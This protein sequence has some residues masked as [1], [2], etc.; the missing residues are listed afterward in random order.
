[1]YFKLNTNTY[2]HFGKIANIHDKKG[3]SYLTYYWIDRLKIL[4]QILWKIGSFHFMNLILILICT[5]YS[6]KCFT[7]ITVEIIDKII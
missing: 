7:V 2:R 4:S 1:M 5:S 3:L 6:Y